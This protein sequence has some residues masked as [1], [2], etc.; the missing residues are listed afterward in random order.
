M[1]IFLDKAPLPNYRLVLPPGGEK[2]LLTVTVSP[3]VSIALDLCEQCQLI[4]LLG[5]QSQ[6]VL[7]RGHPPQHKIHTPVLCIIHRSAG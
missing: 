1:K 3:E 4:L 7:C 6:A 2:N 5:S